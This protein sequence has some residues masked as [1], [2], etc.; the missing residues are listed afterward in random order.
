[1]AKSIFFWHK[2]IVSQSIPSSPR[3][4]VSAAYSAAIDLICTTRRSLAN[5]PEGE[6]REVGLQHDGHIYASNRISMSPARDNTLT[7]FADALQVDGRW[8][9]SNSLKKLLHPVGDGIGVFN[10]L[11]L[12]NLETVAEW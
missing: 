8:A 4:I 11:V 7:K 10:T 5:L 3:L 12:V 2:A 6:V 9:A 1:M